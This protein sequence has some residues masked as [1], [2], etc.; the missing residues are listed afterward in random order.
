MARC[1]ALAILVAVLGIAAHGC[2]APLSPA[3]GAKTE[4]PRVLDGRAR[5]RQIFCSLWETRA[6]SARTAE[7][8]EAALHRLEDEPGPAAGATWAL[9]THDPLLRFLV[10][11]G[12]LGDCSASIATPFEV[13]AEPLRRLGY[14]IETV[15]VGSASSAHNASEIAEAVA[16]VR[17]SPKEKLVLLGYSKGAVDILEFLDAFP[18]LARKVN[19]VVSVAGA[20]YGS[21]LADLYAD[22]YARWLPFVPM[23]SCR[24]ADAGGLESLRPGVRRAW[25]EAHRLPAGARY[26]SVVAF[27]PRENVSWP[28]R[29]SY[30]RLAGIDP[31]NDGQLSLSDQMIPGGT[32]LGFAN[33][34]HWAITLPILEKWPLL[35]MTLATRNSFPRGILIEAILLYL[36]EDLGRESAQSSRTGS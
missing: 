33:A 16:E 6:V 5:F 11:T 15:V 30:D 32:L 23:G 19:A 25:L 8:C 17:L 21:P 34:D 10:V 35:A 1:M 28:L 26:Y 24:P 27:A 14:R 9:P 22:R 2:S 36:A 3:A 18:H 13:E 4:I 31:R 7:R 12:F 29:S 20:I